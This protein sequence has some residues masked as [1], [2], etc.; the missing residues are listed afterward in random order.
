MESATSPSLL[1]SGPETEMEIEEYAHTPEYPEDYEEKISKFTYTDIQDYTLLLVIQTFSDAVSIMIEES[2]RILYHLTDSQINEM[3]SN[4]LVLNWLKSAG[5]RRQLQTTFTNI[6]STNDV[7]KKLDAVN[8]FIK[9]VFQILH[10]SDYF[11]IEYLYGVDR[12]LGHYK[13]V[14]FNFDHSIAYYGYVSTIILIPI[15]VLLYKTESYDYFLS[16]LS[17][18]VLIKK[19]NVNSIVD[20][21]VDIMGDMVEVSAQMYNQIHVINAKIQNMTLL[22]SQEE[23]LLEETEHAAQID[24]LRNTIH[25]KDT[26]INNV[27]QQIAHFFVELMKFTIRERYFK[28]AYDKVIN[29][30]I[31]AGNPDTVRFT[32]VGIM[33]HSIVEQCPK[34]FDDYITSLHTVYISERYANGKKDEEVFPAL[35]VVRAVSK[36]LTVYR[37][38]DINKFIRNLKQFLI[39]KQ[40]LH[41]INRF[42]VEYIKI[43]VNAL[44][45]YH[46][47]DES[48]TQ[49]TFRLFEALM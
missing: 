15:N 22:I 38:S 39:T 17:H 11:N 7:H 1:D 5:Y 31:K 45:K 46:N 9:Y 20:T 3:K 6:Q 19:L 49:E 2:W 44:Y 12:M 25:H 10:K 32:I 40:V 18:S 36:C 13:Y 16:V 47:L 37:F 33:A 43:E 48:F 41:Y 23:D 4:D 29:N 24:E 21:C 30:L 14:G 26:V 27:L 42:N 35:V 8:Q 34:Q 28:I